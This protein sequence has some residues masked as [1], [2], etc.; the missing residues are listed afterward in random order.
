MEG[1][2]GSFIVNML[3]GTPNCRIIRK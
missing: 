3:I 2:S 1:Q